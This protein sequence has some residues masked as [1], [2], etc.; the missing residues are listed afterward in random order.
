MQLPEGGPQQ[1]LVDSDRVLI[2]SGA[3]CEIRLPG[4][5]AAS[6]HVLIT[7]LGGNAYAQARSLQPPPLLNGAPFTE[8]P[9]Q[10]NALLQIGRSEITVSIVEIADQVG[11]TKKQSEPIS[12]FTYVLAILLIPLAL[13][14]LLD[15][16]KDDVLDARPDKTPA[17][18][19]EA[20]AVCPQSA[21]DQALGMAQNRRL[22]A[23]GKRER[24]PFDV[25]DGVGAVPLFQ[26]AAACYRAAGEGAAAAEMQGAADKLSKQLQEDYRAHQMRLVHSLDVKDL[27]TAQREVK[28]LLAMLQ[29]KNDPYVVWLSNMD[30]RLKLRLSGTQKG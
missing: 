5:T 23:Q 2:G 17:L 7:F 22:T 1:L 26:Q 24:S 21:K 6:E 8:A 16:P 10:Q 29:G 13:F 20:S 9:L 19:D 30:R 25:R 28:V 11:V 27:R 18:W 12:P 4:D 15:D 14:V 3:H